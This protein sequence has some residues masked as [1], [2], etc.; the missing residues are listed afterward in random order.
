L[1]G[2]TGVRYVCDM[3]RI[4]AIISARASYSRVRALLIELNKCKEL[5]LRIVLTASATSGRY[6]NLDKFIA[7]DGLTINWRIESQSDASL[8]SSMARTT[9]QTLLGLTDYLQN[10]NISGVLVV[11][12]RHETI[13]GSIAG[14]YLGKTVFHL[15]GGE[16]TGNIDNKVRFANSFLS[17]FHFVATES[18]ALRLRQCGIEPSRI[19]VTGCPSL[20]TIPSV[21]KL[22]IDLSS[23]RGIG[24]SQDK[25][26]NGKFL[27]VM[28]HSETTSSIPYRDQIQKTIESVNNLDLPTLWI[29]PNSDTG[30]ELMV[31]QI[32]KARE[33]G[34]LE[35]VHFERSMS[36]EQFILI[37]MKASCLV[38]NSSVALRECSLIG[39]PAVNIGG[40]QK[41]RDK[42]PNVIDVGF[43]SEKITRAVLS[44]LEIGRY[45]LDNLYG[46]GK[47]S[48]K[49][50]ELIK[51]VI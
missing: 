42:G 2:A 9:A 6:G 39:T 20:D 35:N 33:E 40:R 4:V 8:E 47:A 12:D 38:G 22:E 5:E 36:P 43:D 29:W 44:Q 16:V 19:F 26:L 14:S 50:L 51:K 41:N 10:E 32:R 17:D 23:F 3:K 25:L 31:G 24:L 1:I 48:A 7:E 49:I 34:L 11:A 37:L 21:E 30:S 27:V 46:D 15:Q 28:Q 45:P 18:A 13:A